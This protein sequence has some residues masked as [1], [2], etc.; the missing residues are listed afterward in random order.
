MPLLA[1]Q[2]LRFGVLKELLKAVGF[3]SV[4]LLEHLGD[5]FSGTSQKSMKLRD[6]EP[7]WSGG[8]YGG[9]P[10]RGTG[11]TFICPHC[12]RTHLSVMFSNPL[13]GGEPLPGWRVYWLRSGEDF[14]SLSLSPSINAA[15]QGHWHGFITNG[16]VR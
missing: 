4:R 9:P 15:P 10:R 16:E 13:D 14:D 8:F 3:F 12:M 6:L 7:H 5:T 11:V 2:F 1:H